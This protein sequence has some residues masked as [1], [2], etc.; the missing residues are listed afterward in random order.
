MISIIREDEDTGISV[1]EVNGRYHVVQVSHDRSQ[2][3][4]TMPSD[5]P[6]SG[7]WVGGR[8]DEGV[9]YVSKGRTYSAAMA[10]FRNQVRKNRVASQADI[11]RA[12]SLVENDYELSVE[13]DPTIEERLSHRTVEQVRRFLSEDG[14]SYYDEITTDV[15]AA[16]IFDGALNNVEINDGDLD[17]SPLD[18]ILI[19]LNHDH[20]S[21]ASSE[22][23]EIEGKVRYLI[24]KHK[25]KALAA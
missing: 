10:G 20:V 21:L 12:Y 1:V 3:F 24:S 22:V 16:K 25:S 14:C 18:M 4:S 6:T 11:D 8:S 17:L 5:M 7:I 9:K 19:Y 13:P 15:L 2:V 23:D